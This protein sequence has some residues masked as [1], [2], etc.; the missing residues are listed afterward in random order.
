[1]KG[2][3]TIIF[4]VLAAVAPVLETAGVDLG[5]EGNALTAYAFGVAIVNLVLRFFTS[6]PVGTK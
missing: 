3:K 5:L 2:Y 4:N 6:T 1:M